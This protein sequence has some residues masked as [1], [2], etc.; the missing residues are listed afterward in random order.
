MFRTIYVV[1]VVT[2]S[3]IVALPVVLL[4][5][6]FN[7]GRQII[8]L[9]ATMWGRLSLFASGVRLKTKGLENIN[10]CR[11]Q[12]LMSNHQSIYDIFA[13]ISAIPLPFKWLAK[14]ELFRIPV[15]G[16]LMALVGHVSIDRLNPKNATASISA[17]QTKIQNGASILIFP[18][19][20]RSYDGKL[21]AFKKGGFLLALKTKAPIVPI[22]IIGSNEVMKRDDMRVYPGEI[23]L[24]IDK[25]IET[26][27]L[28]VK[29]RKY[30]MQKVQDVIS[31]NLLENL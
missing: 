19:G 23:K 16:W 13:L 9:Y 20:T 17:A 27:H 8:Q 12:I 22:S 1:T 15:L 24:I 26:L 18:E 30:L 21:Q 28:R 31:K 14:K 10:T 4:C 5:L 3:T 7:R 11:S 6:P 2:L 29:D 25:P